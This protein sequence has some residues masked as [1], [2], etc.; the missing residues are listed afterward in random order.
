[1]SKLTSIL[2]ASL[3]ATSAAAQDFAVTQPTLNMD[4]NR[5]TIG[6]S[7]SGTAPA[8]RDVRI[9]FCNCG[10]RLGDTTPGFTETSTLQPFPDWYYARGANATT[11]KQ[12]LT[13]G[14][15]IQSVV[16]VA[17]GEYGQF[18]LVFVK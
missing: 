3:F 11:T 10:S 16:M 5:A 6:L 12:M 8:V 15:K 7:I 1:M 9:L 18:Y 17:G 13:D 14:W 2:A 4:G